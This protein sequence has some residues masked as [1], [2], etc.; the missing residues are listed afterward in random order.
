MKKGKRG[1][2]TNFIDRVSF[3]SGS[4]IHLL[5][6]DALL[7]RHVRALLD[8]HVRA[9]LDHHVVMPRVVKPAPPRVVQPA[10]R[11]ASPAVAVVDVVAV[12]AVVEVVS[13]V[14]VV[15]LGAVV[16]LVSVTTLSS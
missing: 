1:S 4:S 7:D 11:P 13:V 14:D 9:L 15:P 8:H 3:V 2:I 10:R 6:L 5:N 16:E 12:G